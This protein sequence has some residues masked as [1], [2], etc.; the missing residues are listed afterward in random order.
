MDRIKGNLDTK[1]TKVLKNTKIDIKINLAALWLVFMMLYIYTDFYKLY[2]PEKIE[3]I[4]SGVMDCIL[5]T[6]LSLLIIAVVTIIPACMIFLSLVL[7]AKPNRILNIVL[8]LCHI[9]IGIV[10]LVG[11]TWYFYIL[12]GVLLI[13]VA[14][15]ILLTAWTW[16]TEAKNDSIQLSS[17]V[18][19]IKSAE[20]L[21]ESPCTERT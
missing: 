4:M 5:V 2:M 7:N 6:Q 1:T 9:G 20:E 12:Y 3:T 14:I 18:G 19:K 17:Y 16:P 21:L 13:L 15:L 11:S 8:G 10:N